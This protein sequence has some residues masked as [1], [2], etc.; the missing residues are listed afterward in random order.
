MYFKRV[1]RLFW[2]LFSQ[3][4]LAPPSELQ[5]G[6]PAPGPLLGPRLSGPIDMLY[7]YTRNPFQRE[8][9]KVMQLIQFR[10]T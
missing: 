10:K 1:S 7:T 8:V 9:L 2:Q 6:A 3:I 5:G 4:P